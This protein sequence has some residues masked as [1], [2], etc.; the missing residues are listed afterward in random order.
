MF[1]F[2]LSIDSGSIFFAKKRPKLHTGADFY[3]L[4]LLSIIIMSKIILLSIFQDFSE[5][6]DTGVTSAIQIGPAR[7][8]HSCVNISGR[9]QLLYWIFWCVPTFHK[10]T[11]KGVLSFAGRQV[12]LHWLISN[13]FWHRNT[14]VHGVCEMSS[15]SL[16]SGNCSLIETQVKQR[17]RGL[18]FLLILRESKQSV[19][20]QQEMRNQT[21]QIQ[22]LCN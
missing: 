21:R 18:L 17:K 7:H 14:L 5:H 6:N 16:P 2:L 19:S 12:R 15:P 10:S 13:P 9:I 3:H 1:L 8:D 20:T 11:S 22:D 4:R